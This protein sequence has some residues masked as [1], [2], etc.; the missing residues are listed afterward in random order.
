MASKH[1]EALGN[2]TASKEVGVIHC[3]VTKEGHRDNKGEK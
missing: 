3:R 2:N 1:I